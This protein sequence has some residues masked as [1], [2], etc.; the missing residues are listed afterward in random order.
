[1]SDTTEPRGSSSQD[2]Q[3]PLNDTAEMRDAIRSI[4]AIGEDRVGGDDEAADTDA[5]DSTDSGTPSS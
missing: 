5:P 3:P 4:E 2:S 1:M